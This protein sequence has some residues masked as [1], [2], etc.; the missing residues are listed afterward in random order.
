MVD[1]YGQY[2]KIKEEID[3]NIQNVI[4]ST[5]FVKGP[6]VKLFE[7][8]LAEYLDVGHVIACANGTDALQIAL[9]SLNLEPGDE[10][11][12]S[13]F[14]FIA[15]VEVIALLGL[16]P[17]LVDVDPETFLMNPEDIENAITPKT[18]AIVPVHL[19]GQ[20]C[21]MDAIIKIGKKYN[22]RIIEDAAQSIGS[23]FIFSPTKKRKSG[24][25][26]D[27]GCTSF[28][29][30]KN[31]G[32]FGDGGAIFIN[33]DQL[34]EDIR[35]I[36]N[37]GMKVRYHHDRIG[38]NSRLDGIQAAILRSKLKYLDDYC[39]ERIKV[40]NY[41]D[42]E[43]KS[44]PSLKIPKRVNNSTHVFH[45][46][47]LKVDDNRRDELKNYLNEK[48]IPSMIYYPIPLHKQ[49][50]F[51]KYE[52]KMKDFPVSNTLVDKVLSLPIH[53]EMTEEQFQYITY[54]I[55]EFLN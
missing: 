11:I 24:T 1:L 18:K 5:S 2:L 35:S 7:N 21:N 26:G 32:C 27:I 48:S 9:M 34:A 55:K 31:L 29:P 3:R 46:Y 17:V 44:V 12:T 28:F 42:S 51:N 45:Q 25:M 53:T 33:D 54:T 41:Y 30:S 10:V 4:N 50:A 49:T 37:H 43:F 22:V 8:E 13:N 19:F 47:T 20:N 6:E 40:A 36:A 23:D 16:T 38:V 15:T 39:K 14:T 52:S